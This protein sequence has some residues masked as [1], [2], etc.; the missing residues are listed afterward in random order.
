MKKIKVIKMNK[1]PDCAVGV[2]YR[3]SANS[4][5]LIYTLVLPRNCR[6]PEV[7]VNLTFRDAGSIVGG[8]QVNFLSPADAE[9]FMDKY[10]PGTSFRVF[11]SQDTTTPII[12]AGSSVAYLDKP[13]LTW[14]GIDQRKLPADIKKRLDANPVTNTL[15]DTKDVQKAAA[16]ETTAETIITSVKEN[17]L[18]NFTDEFTQ[19]ENNNNELLFKGKNIPLTIIVDKANLKNVPPQ[20]YDIKFE[21]QKAFLLDDLFK[22]SNINLTTQQQ[23]C[24]NLCENYAY[25]SRVKDFV[26][27]KEVLAILDKMFNLNTDQSLCFYYV[28]D[29]NYLKFYASYTIYQPYKSSTS[30]KNKIDKKIKA[31]ADSYVVLMIQGFKD[32]IKELPASMQELTSFVT[33]FM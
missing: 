8:T 14:S 9:A 26:A 17:L 3:V 32:L 31:L 19:T 1:Y 6:F 18:G 28:V 29:N 10:F 12:R 30:D 5:T 24:K 21:F 33:P 25:I 7:G 2:K 16:K 23:L 27:S 22:G 20:I 11:K 4:G 15:A 13:N